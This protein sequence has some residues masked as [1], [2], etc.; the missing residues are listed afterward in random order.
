LTDF[1]PSLYLTGKNITERMGFMELL[2]T[3]RLSSKGQVVIPEDVRNSLKL[4][5]G[6]QFVVIGRDDTVILKTI[7]APSIKEF[8]EMLDEAKKQAKT[9]GLKKTDI[10]RIIREVRKRNRR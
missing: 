7:S 1:H 2:A 8:S 5:A 10:D 4:K 9:A 6:D 3:T